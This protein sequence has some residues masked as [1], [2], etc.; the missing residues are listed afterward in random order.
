MSLRPTAS[1]TLENCTF[2]REPLL[3]PFGFKG[4]Y[5]SEAWQSCVRLADSDGGLHVG[6]GTQSVLWSDATVFRRHTQSESNG[7]MFLTTAWAVR[8]DLRSKPAL[9]DDPV[10]DRCPPAGRGHD[11]RAG[12]L[13]YNA[14]RRRSR[15]GL[16]AAEDHDESAMDRKAQIRARL[17]V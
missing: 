4:A 1:T 7:L 3:A 5:V 2:E 12:A 11:D 13:C 16:P 9:F 15:F 17:P 10:A 8:R 6:L 14:E